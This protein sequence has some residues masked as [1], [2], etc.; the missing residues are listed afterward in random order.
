[1]A[2]APPSASACVYAWPRWKP[3]RPIS[4]GWDGRTRGRCWVA[5]Q[6]FGT[7]E[8]GSGN[9]ALSLATLFIRARMCLAGRARSEC[10]VGADAG[11]LTH[12]DI[13]KLA[14]DQQALYRYR[15]AEHLMELL[16]EGRRLR[17]DMPGAAQDWLAITADA[18]R[19]LVGRMHFDEDLIDYFEQE[20]IDPRARHYQI[21][22]PTE[23]VIGVGGISRAVLHPPRPY[24]HLIPPEYGAGPDDIPAREMPFMIEDERGARD[25]G[26][27]I[28]TNDPGTTI[29]RVDT[30]MVAAAARIFPGPEGERLPSALRCLLLAVY[31]DLTV[32]LVRDAHYRS[33]I[34]PAR[35]NKKAARKAP[36]RIRFLPR[37]IYEGRRREQARQAGESPPPTLVS[38]H[39]RRLGAD[40][41]A[42][43][44]ARLRAQEWDVPVPE[45]FTFVA[46]FYRPATR[47]RPPSVS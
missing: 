1:M 30:P 5:T 13:R 17:D 35:G 12:T 34:P 19:R 32:P 26:L 3:N 37:V 36:E 16:P 7:I 27:F 29:T 10:L 41:H 11:G 8:R 23:V 31:R 40:A 9:L 43:E 2:H 33:E 45:G 46:P 38:A 42:S 14:A 28:I 39:I 47:I 15:A 4:S 24:A 25:Y 22:Q 18:I 21:S 6:R 20:I 44:R